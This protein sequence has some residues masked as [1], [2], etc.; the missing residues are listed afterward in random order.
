M[1][2]TPFHAVW[3][4]SQ[5][6][7]LA[8]SKAWLLT[9]QWHHQKPTSG[10]HV[11]DRCNI[12]RQLSKA[13][14]QGVRHHANDWMTVGWWRQCHKQY[15]RDI[16][17]YSH[18]I[19]AFHPLWALWVVTI[20]SPLICG[21]TWRCLINFNWLCGWWSFCPHYMWILMETSNKHKPSGYLVSQTHLYN[22]AQQEASNVSISGNP[23]QTM[24]K[25]QDTYLRKKQFRQPVH[26][27][28]HCKEPTEN[29]WRCWDFN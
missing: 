15:P 18:R 23:G 19:Y 10:I 4:S 12:Y 5:N 20:L 14:I 26:L 7:L 28:C 24:H 2:F 8:S 25:R 6:I 27:A 21:R 3:F 17:H 16:W 13:M 22:F 29:L 1:E 9:S 11:M